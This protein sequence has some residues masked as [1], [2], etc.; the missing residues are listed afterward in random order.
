MFSVKGALVGLLPVGGLV[1][2]ALNYPYMFHSV[3]SF[4][5]WLCIIPAVTSF[6]AMNYTGSSTYTSLS[7]VLKEMRVSLPIQIG[8][9]FIGIVLWITG[10]FI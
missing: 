10:L 4:I 9:A 8:A 2:Y 3:F 6:I 7:G 5:A 1:W